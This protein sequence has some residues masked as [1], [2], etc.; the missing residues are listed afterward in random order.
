MS[1]LRVPLAVGN[2]NKLERLK[3]LEAYFSQIKKKLEV[4]CCLM[5]IQPF[6]SIKADVYSS[7]GHFLLTTGGYCHSTVMFVLQAGERR[8]EDSKS[9]GAKS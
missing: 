4:G 8:E 9:D 3:L 2:R 6:D 7:L 5:L 1:G